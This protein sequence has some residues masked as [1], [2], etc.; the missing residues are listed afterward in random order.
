MLTWGG[1]TVFRKYGS[2]QRGVKC[3]K[4]VVSVD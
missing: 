2:N 4:K 1:V 3:I